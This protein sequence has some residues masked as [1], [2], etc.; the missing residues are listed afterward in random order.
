MLGEMRR[1]AVLGIAAVLVVAFAVLWVV[2]VVAGP[3][4][5]CGPFDEATCERIVAEIIASHDDPA[6]VLP[7]SYRPPF[8]PVTSVVLSGTEGSVDYEIH[9]LFGGVGVISD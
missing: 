3:T 8:L 5:D 2:P 9:W 6:E 4:I 7:D 1:V